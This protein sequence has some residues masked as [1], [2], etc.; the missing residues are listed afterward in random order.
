[1]KMALTESDL[2]S[3]PGMYLGEENRE[4]IRIQGLRTYSFQ[5]RHGTGKRAK[6]WHLNTQTYWRKQPEH[7][8]SPG[9]SWQ[10]PRKTELPVNDLVYILGAPNGQKIQTG[11]N[12]ER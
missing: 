5:N 1:M 3:Y 7:V 10:W 11:S 8:R 4:R 6:Y 12:R 2:E 9:V